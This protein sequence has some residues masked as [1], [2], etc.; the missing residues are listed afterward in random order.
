ML[1]VIS[2]VVWQAL[3]AGVVTLVLAWMA[4]NTQQQIKA[5]HTLVNSASLAQLKV[6]A[7][8][9]GRLA[10][11]THD[12]D[13]IAAAAEARNLYAQHEVKQA[14]VDARN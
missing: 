7:V 1:A 2:D 6:S 5:V 11:I 4:H 9:L 14:K 8:A 3:I 12:P 13:D 10:A